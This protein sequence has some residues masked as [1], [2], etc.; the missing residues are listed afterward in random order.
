MT[1]VQRFLV[2][3]SAAL[4]LDCSRG[5]PAASED[6][7]TE[8]GLVRSP[9]AEI[10]ARAQ[11]KGGSLEIARAGNVRYIGPLPTIDGRHLRPKVLLRSGHLALV[12]DDGYA[13]IVR[14]GLRSVID[15][16]SEVEGRAAPDAPWVIRTTRH[17]VVSLPNVAPR[18]AQ[19]YVQMLDALEP[20]LPRVFAHLGAADALPALLHCG[21][22]QGRACAAMA[23]VLLTLGVPA[24][25]IIDDFA[26]NQ[27]VGIDPQWL[28]GVFARVDAAGGIDAYLGAHKVAATNIASLRTQAIE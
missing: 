23:I 17:I 15:F 18:S 6:P 4:L 28:D 25:D 24:K 10:N 9:S 26:N 19:A 1:R 20:A 3:A 11:I 16:R 5:G 21:T 27:E 2:C 22:G 7:N 13:E 8:L 14:L 12:N